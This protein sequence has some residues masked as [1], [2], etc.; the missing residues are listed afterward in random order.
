V[1]VVECPAVAAIFGLTTVGGLQTP[2]GEL[3]SLANN[4]MVRE[5]NI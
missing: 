1:K 5:L 4:S 3:K 2:V